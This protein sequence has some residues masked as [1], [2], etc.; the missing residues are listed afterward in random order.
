MDPWKKDSNSSNAKKSIAQLVAGRQQTGGNETAMGHSNRERTIKID[1]QMLMCH[2][3]TPLF[4]D[5]MVLPP[6]RER[7]PSGKM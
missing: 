2:L 6:S 7:L 4:A 3:P 5:P 1:N